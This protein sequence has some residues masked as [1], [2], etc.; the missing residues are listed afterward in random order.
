MI[1]KIISGA[2][3]VS[4][5]L[6]AGCG[7]GGGGVTVPPPTATLSSQAISVT[8]TNPPA[9]DYNVDLTVT[10]APYSTAITSNSIIIKQVRISYT[11]TSNSTSDAPPTLPDQYGATGQTPAAGGSVT[12]SQLVA[13]KAFINKWII[14]KNFVPGSGSIWEYYI[15]YYITAV[16]DNTSKDLSFS[17][18]GGK[19]I[20]N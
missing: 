15:T 16:E 1:K 11:K 12:L 9:T 20:F 5:F 10:S 7:S 8:V 6:V 19:I 13:S 3:L 18:A 14:E 2:V 4:L 17:L